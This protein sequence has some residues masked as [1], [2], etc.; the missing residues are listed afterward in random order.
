MTCPTTLIVSGNRV[1]KDKRDIA[2]SFVA[3]SIGTLK[4]RNQIARASKI[5]V[6]DALPAA[7]T[8]QRDA[9]ILADNGLQNHLLQVGTMMRF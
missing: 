1:I 7:F 6:S 9:P 4:L 8:H 2:L 3:Y 5:W